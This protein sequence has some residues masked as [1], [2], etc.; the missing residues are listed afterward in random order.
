MSTGSEDWPSCPSGSSKPTRS[1]RSPT[2]MNSTEGS[3]PGCFGM[4]LKY[5]ITDAPS[6]AAVAH[7]DR[8]NDVYPTT[9][10]TVRTPASGVRQVSSPLLASHLHTAT[11]SGSVLA[12]N[13]TS[14]SETST[15]DLTSMS[16]G[17]TP[18]PSTIRVSA[19]PMPSTVT[20]RPSASRAGTPSTRSTQ[21]ASDWVVSSL[22][23]PVTGS[24][25]KPQPFAGL[26]TG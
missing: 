13:R 18:C 3:T 24:A 26:E 15:T 7:P 8:A 5:V 25:A 16:A 6:D 12:V 11:E 9:S 19:S 1:C 2:V 22:V 10:D 21:W 14:A 4:G 20:S 17:V 23:L